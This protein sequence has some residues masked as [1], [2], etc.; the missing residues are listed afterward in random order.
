MIDLHVHSNFSDGKA[1]VVGIARKAKE[2]GLKA[3][4]IVDHSLELSFGLDEKKAKLR[5][6]EI[7]EAR[8][9]YG[10][11][12]YSGVEC[13][14]NHSGEI[15]L[16]LHNFDFIIVSVHEN[17]G[18]Y[19]ERV[20]KCVEKNSIDVLGHPL[21]EMFPVLRDEKLEEAMLDV[22]EKYG[23]ALELNSTHKCPPEDFL[24]KCAD[25]KIKVS[26]GSDAHTL[27]KVGKVGWC[28]ER[29]KKYLRRAELFIP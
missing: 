13:G 18:N 17:A 2:I 20:I 16:P 12:I 3:I 14:I 22:I 21:S 25:R 5:E 9:L 7:E 11:K 26:I 4:A 19:Y 1:S 23:V 29:R 10:I 6:I 24:L 15:F 27:E 28:E 8:D